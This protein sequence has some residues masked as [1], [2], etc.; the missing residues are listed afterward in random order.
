MRDVVIVAGARTA[1]GN[2]NGALES[3]DP[4][5]L[6]VIALKGAIGKAGIAANEIQAVVAGHCN[7]ASS[8]GNSGRHIALKSGLDA[9]S[10]ACT[11]HQQCAS[12]MRAAEMVAQ[13]ILLGK[14]EVG[15]AGI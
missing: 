3:F 15:A 4:V 2:F 7:Q 10:F 5:D 1:I 9:E 11:V 12:S 14:I 13:D 6:G 8:A